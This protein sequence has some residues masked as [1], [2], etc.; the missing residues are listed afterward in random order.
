VSGEKIVRHND[1]AQE[2]E[3]SKKLERTGRNKF[4]LNQSDGT[5][6]LARVEY[7]DDCGNGHK[8]FSIT[9]TYFSNGEFVSGGCIHDL[10]AN[11]I[12]ELVPYFKWH[13]CSSEGPLHY[14][15]NTMYL[16][17]ERDCW[18]CLK[19]EV[20]SY[21][22]VLKFKDFPIESPFDKRFLEWLESYKP[23]RFMLEAVKHPKDPK[24]FG[25]KY[26]FY[27]FHCQWHECPFDSLR[28]AKQWQ[29]ALVKFPYTIEN[30]PDAWGE[31]KERDLDSARKVAIWP[32]ATDEDLTTPG[33][34]ERLEARLPALL[35]EF[36]KA[37]EHF[38]FEF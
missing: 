30:V 17:G 3:L 23:T 22:K 29:E 8:T 4:Y 1:F 6:V 19:G 35:L 24:T 21:R 9:G 12:P 13:L 16:A 14:I 18:G 15:S 26:T 20:R 27:D 11:Y 10:I 33:L 32:E 31:G 2:L 28:A 38:G 5:G 36:R 34:K 25:C 7:C 37:V